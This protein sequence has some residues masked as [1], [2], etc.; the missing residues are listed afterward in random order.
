MV[1]DTLTGHS[2]SQLPEYFKDV[3]TEQTGG[4]H[5]SAAFMTFCHREFIH[6]QWKILLDD[7]F[8]EAWQHGCPILCSDGVTRRFYIRIFSH[9]GDYPEKYVFVCSRGLSLIDFE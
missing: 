2:H 4:V 9:S 1:C 6:G 8:I 7:D 5:P 3:A